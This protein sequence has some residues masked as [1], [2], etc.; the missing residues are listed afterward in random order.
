MIKIVLADTSPE[1]QRLCGQLMQSDPEISIVAIAENG[2]EAVKLVKRHTPSLLI[3]AI[4]N[5]AYDVPATVRQIMADFPVP[6]ILASSNFNT[7]S[8]IHALQLGAVGTI[9]RP[10]DIQ[11]TVTDELIQKT[12]VVVRQMANI[13]VT[14][15]SP[16]A[17]L[18]EQLP[19]QNKTGITVPVQKRPDIIVIG[20]STGGPQALETIVSAIPANFSFPVLILQHITS[21]FTEGFREWLQ[22]HA[23]IPVQMAENG[24]T[25]LPGHCYLAP[26]GTHIELSENNKFRLTAAPPEHG[27]RPSISVLFRSIGTTYS[28]NA[29]A[30]LLSGMGKD[31]AAELGLIRGR[32]GITIAQDEATSL[33]FGMPAEAMKLGTAEYTMSP[34]Q[35]AIFLTNLEKC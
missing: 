13:R 6:I 15:R 18:R 24:Q 5:P 12:L 17:R 3:L 9:D 32:G 25:F 8:P 21:G 33:I 10:V 16:N 29:I 19:E 27:S 22:A 2:A 26:E 14:R 20:A 1:M 28:G 30:I 34:E 4:D 7:C 35:I 23:Q 11:N 31:G